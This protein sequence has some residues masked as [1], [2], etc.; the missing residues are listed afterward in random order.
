VRRKTL[1]KKIMRSIYLGENGVRTDKYFKN[2]EERMR[3]F[4]KTKEFRFGITVPVRGEV[5]IYCDKGGEKSA[6][7]EYD[8]KQLQEN[9]DEVLVKKLEPVVEFKNFRRKGKLLAGSHT[10]IGF[11]SAM[12]DCEYRWRK[13]EEK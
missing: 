13:K 7:I 5:R 2:K 8:C 6:E 11:L 3:K 9:L 10:L 1:L 12:R 4:I